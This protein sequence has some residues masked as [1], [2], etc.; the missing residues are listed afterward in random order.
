MSPPELEQTW[1]YRCT[2]RERV[3][4]HRLL[5]P[6]RLVPQMHPLKVWE[7]LGRQRMEEWANQHHAA[8]GHKECQFSLTFPASFSSPF[9][10]SLVLWRHLQAARGTPA[11]GRPFVRSES[12]RLGAVAG[13]SVH[14]P[15]RSCQGTA[16][17]A[18]IPKSCV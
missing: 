7:D 3:T 15:G 2:F 14:W 5:R 18:P 16:R 1:T 12:R 9:S 10:L 13:H 6:V 11:A 8:F 17:T 4:W